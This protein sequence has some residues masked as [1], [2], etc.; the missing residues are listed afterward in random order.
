MGIFTFIHSLIQWN[1][2]KLYQTLSPSF[3]LSLYF[4]FLSHFRD[5]ER[6]LSSFNNPLATHT[7]RVTFHHSFIF[8]TPII[9][10]SVSNVMHFL[11]S[12]EV[13][14]ATSKLIQFFGSSLETSPTTNPLNLIP[15]LLILI[16]HMI[17]V[18][19][20][21]KLDNNNGNSILIEIRSY[22]KKNVCSPWKWKKIKGNIFGQCNK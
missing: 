13:W 20:Y 3:F 18:Y 22:G 12:T 19:F 16:T 1:S 4:C 11:G 17:R 21:Y 6:E 7:M 15:S 8:A 14:K 9:S 10:N 5:R 2:L